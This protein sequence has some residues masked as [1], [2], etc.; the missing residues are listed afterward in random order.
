MSMTSYVG[1]YK[2]LGHNE[3]R[4]F[5]NNSLNAAIFK[6]KVRVKKMIGH[7][8]KEFP[9]S[10]LMVSIYLTN[11]RLMF[12]VIREND[13]S[14]LRKRG[15]PALTGLEGSWYEIPVSTIRNV[16]AVY[17]E[18]SQDRELRELVPSM[19]NQGTVSLVEIDYEG[20]RT[21]GNLTEYMASMFDAPGLAK[22]F[23]L[24]ETV[25]LGSIVQLIGDQNVSLVPKLK[26]ML[27]SH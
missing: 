16:E 8:V 10:S 21:S 12:L 22:I 11:R 7:E 26:G 3:Q 25:E 13:A 23:G 20:N 27:V 18:V 15:V 6:K 4:I 9:V 2:Q 19:A 5:E 14:G 17:M 24:K 1:L